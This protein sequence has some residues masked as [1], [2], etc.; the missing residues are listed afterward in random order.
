MPLQPL[1]QARIHQT[2][3]FIIK[4]KPEALLGLLGSGEE[5][6]MLV[7][8]TE[9]ERRGLC[10]VTVCRYGMA[11]GKTKLQAWSD[12]SIYWQWCQTISDG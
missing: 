12:H 1:D 11:I 5:A 8:N 9:C 10:W 3:R 6:V 4:I 2:Y 7:S